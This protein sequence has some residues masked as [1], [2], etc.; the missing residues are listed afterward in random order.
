MIKKFWR[1]QKNKKNMPQ[2]KKRNTKKVKLKPES[3]LKMLNN[4]KKRL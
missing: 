1:P 3:A 4:A 2:K